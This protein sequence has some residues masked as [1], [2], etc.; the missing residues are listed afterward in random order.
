MRTFL[1]AAAIAVAGTP[2]AAQTAKAPPPTA[3]RRPHPSRDEM[4]PSPAVLPAGAQIAVLDGDPGKA[5]PFT[6]RFKFPDG[7]KIAPH[8]HS[9][10]ENITVVQAHVQG[11]DGRSVHSRRPARFPGRSFLKMPARA[12]HFATAKGE[13]IVQIHGHRPVRPDLR[14]PEG[15]AEAVGAVAALERRNLAQSSRAMRPASLTQNTRRSGAEIDADQVTISPPATC[16][17]K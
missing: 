4:G 11:R 14:R 12:P 13:V 8:W 15:R 10:D 1:L 17:S 3:A 9:M 2:V 6:I 5:G 16:W 7:Y